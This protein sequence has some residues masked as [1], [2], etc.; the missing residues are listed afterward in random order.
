[1]THIKSLGNILLAT[2]L[3]QAIALMIV[4]AA[5]LGLVGCGSGDDTAAPTPTQAASPPQAQ[6]PPHAG[7]PSVNAGPDQTVK[8][9]ERAILHGSVTPESDPVCWQL[10]SKPQFSQA[11]I[12]TCCGTPEGNITPDVPGQYVLALHWFD[13]GVSKPAADTVVITAVETLVTMKF[14][15]TLGSGT[16]GDTGHVAG[17]FTYVPTQGPSATNLRGFHD[18]VGYQLRSWHFV[19]EPGDFKELPFTEYQGGVTG[20][21][22]EFCQGNCI[23]ASGNLVVVTFFN[24][25]GWYLRI[26]FNTA[27]PTP[28]MNPPANRAEWGSP[29]SDVYR[30]LD[31]QG[32]FMIINSTSVTLEE[33]Q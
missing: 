23:F 12:V 4:L 1:M 17:T 19:V 2:A 6:N 3:L 28:F 29:T 32:S 10:V 18:N 25:S 31:E 14:T 24:D 33:V 7:I 30:R 20:N 27:D 26:A 15:G 8:V 13:C 16:P 21:A 5:I 11:T 22:A 9:G